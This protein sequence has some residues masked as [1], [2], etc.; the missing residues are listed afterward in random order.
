MFGFGSL[1]FSLKVHEK[2]VRWH[3]AAFSDEVFVLEEGDSECSEED[4]GS[5]SQES[6]AGIEVGLALRMRMTMV[7]LSRL[8]I[9]SFGLLLFFK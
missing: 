5:H 6:G 4:E 1:V 7:V 8:H 2:E 9:G 3:Q